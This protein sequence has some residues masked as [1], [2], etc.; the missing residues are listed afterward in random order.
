MTLITE[1]E[2]NGTQYLYIGAMERGPVM[3]P[4][5]EHV[6]YH[7]TQLRF[8]DPSLAAKLTEILGNEW[9]T[10]EIKGD[11]IVLKGTTK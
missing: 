2:R 1:K 10:M 5:N 9:V 11:S 6:T 4:Q 3:V 8:F 7:L